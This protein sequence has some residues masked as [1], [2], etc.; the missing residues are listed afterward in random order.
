MIREILVVLV[1]L[2]VD[3]EVMLVLH[4]HA[5][6][7]CFELLLVHLAV[8]PVEGMVCVVVRT[9]QALGAT[10]VLLGIVGLLRHLVGELGHTGLL[11]LSGAKVWVLSI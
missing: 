6:L 3:P 10:V 11:V 1:V 7:V 4:L 8:H 2:G 5:H 9:G